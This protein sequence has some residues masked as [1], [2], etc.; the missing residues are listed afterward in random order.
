MTRRGFLARPGS[1]DHWVAAPDSSSAE[2]LRPPAT[3]TA[4]LTIDVTPD[5]RRRLK[6]AALTRGTTVADM[7][8]LLAREFPDAKGDAP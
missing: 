5:L 8:E 1:P 7:R 6:L 3:F 2:A 4:R